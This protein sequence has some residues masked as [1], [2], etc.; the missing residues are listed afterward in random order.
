MSV[1]IDIPT[2]MDART[3]HLRLM[4]VAIEQVLK[5]VLPDENFSVIIN[6]K[7]HEKLIIDWFAVN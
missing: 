4:S 3:I 7:G 6:Y 1:E 2:T 5:S